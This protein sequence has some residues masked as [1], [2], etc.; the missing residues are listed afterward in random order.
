MPPILS[1]VAIATAKAYGFTG[2]LPTIPVEYLV[3]AGGGGGGSTT[4]PPGAGGAGG[5][6][7]GYLTSDNSVALLVEFNQPYSVI[8]GGGGAG[9]LFN[10]T[11]GTNGSD[12]QFASIIFKRRWSGRKL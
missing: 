5:G 8:V 7:G 2:G 1:S 12:S 11:L 9:G 3:V 6:G 4:Q 10:S